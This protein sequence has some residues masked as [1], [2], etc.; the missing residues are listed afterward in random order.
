MRTL[1]DPDQLQALLPTIC[2][3]ET[4]MD[5]EHWSPENPLLGHCAVVSCVAQNLFGGKLLR[6]SLAEYQ[7]FASMGSHYLLELPDGRHADFTAPQFGDRYPA[8][9][10]LAPRERAYVLSFPETRRRYALLAF[11]L[12]AALSVG[13]PL[14]NDDIYRRCMLAAFGSP[15]KKMGFGC[16]ITRGGEVVYDGSNAVIEPL[17]SLCDPTCIAASPPRSARSTSPAPQ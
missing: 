13:N 14:F 2:D 3:A 4:S 1:T 5:P 6:A 17:K 12:A 9:M 15:C 7:E 8:G 11:R 16:V 10:K